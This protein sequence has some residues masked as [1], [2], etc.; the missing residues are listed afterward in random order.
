MYQFLIMLALSLFSTALPSF[1]TATHTEMHSIPEMITVSAHG[2]NDIFNK[3]VTIQAP[4]FLDTKPLAHDEKKQLKKKLGL[5]TSGKIVKEMLEQDLREAA[6]ICL[7]LKEYDDVLT[8][9]RQMIKITQSSTVVKT[10]KLEIADVYFQQGNLKIAAKLYEEYISLYPG[11]KK[12]AAYAEYKQLLS[13]NSL[14]L[15]DDRDQTMTLKT[16]ILADLFLE[17]QGTFVKQYAPYVEA[18]KHDCNS[19]LYKHDVTVFD[20][21]LKKKSFKAAEVRLDAIKTNFLSKRPDLEPEIVNCELR[22]AQAKNDSVK[23]AELSEKLAQKFP[24]YA[25]TQMAQGKK[26]KPYISL[27]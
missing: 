21:Y 7:R 2:A 1:L 20:Y 3:S 9:L 16:K 17:K 25:G 14:R 8:Y 19:Q 15:E 24:D 22:V 23:I 11:D 10:V 27:F 4:T 6:N 18:I 13:S 12:T 5:L 26:G